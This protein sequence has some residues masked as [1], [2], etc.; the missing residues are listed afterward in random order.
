[1]LFYMDDILMVRHNEAN[2]KSLKKNL[3]KSFAMKGL[4]P[5]KKFNIE[6]L[7]VTKKNT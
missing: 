1:M 4:G 6:V 2:I 7:G 5:A 3:N